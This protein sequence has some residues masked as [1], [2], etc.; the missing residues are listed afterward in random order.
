MKIT[1]CFEPIGIVLIVT[2]LF[3]LAAVALG[4]DSVTVEII[5]DE[6]KRE[7]SEDIGKMIEETKG[8]EDIEVS[9]ELRTI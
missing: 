4:V 9:E 3:R 7:E 5:V 6:L 8:D 1:N 2:L